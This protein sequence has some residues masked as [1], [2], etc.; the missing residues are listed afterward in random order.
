MRESE[1]ER[2]QEREGEREEREGEGEGKGREDEGEGERVFVLFCFVLWLTELNREHLA[3][4]TVLP[5]NSQ[6]FKTEV[7]V[8]NVLQVFVTQFT[9]FIFT[10][11]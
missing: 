5:G 10:W 8:L 11:L 7:V 1:R 6:V 4:K 2:E 3:E 9:A